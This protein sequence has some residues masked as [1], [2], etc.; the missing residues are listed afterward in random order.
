MSLLQAT[1]PEGG[2]GP[3]R[4][5]PGWC[6][7]CLYTLVDAGGCGWVLAQGN[8]V[9]PAAACL[10]AKAQLGGAGVVAPQAVVASWL[11]GG[12]LTRQR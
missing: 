6:W 4:S 2:G 9:Q 7:R 5:W 10:L 3:C 8:Q 1:R 12:R 11:R